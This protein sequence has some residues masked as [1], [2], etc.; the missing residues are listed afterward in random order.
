MTTLDPARAAEGHDCGG[1]PH[2]GNIPPLHIVGHDHDVLRGADCACSAEALVSVFCG[3]R[4]FSAAATARRI[5]RDAA[6]AERLGL[7]AVA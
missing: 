6:I 2:T 4:F 3:P 5:G 7:L 1:L